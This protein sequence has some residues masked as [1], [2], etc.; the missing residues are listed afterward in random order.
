MSR[1]WILVAPASRGI[2]AHLT[3]HLLRTTTAPILA[4]CRSPDTT[5]VKQSILSSL[6]S[7]D[8]KPKSHSSPAAKETEDLASRL[9][10]VTLD[11][12]SEP[13][14]AAAAAEAAS[15]FPSSTH[16]LR[17]ALATPGIL[18][19][20]KSPA[21]IDY[22]DALETFRVNTL[23]QMMLMKHFSPFLPK[24]SVKFSTSSSPENDEAR[25]LP[26][27]HAVWAAMSARVGSTA[28]NRKGGWY[29]YRA[30][31]AGVTS[32]AKSLDLWLAARS[33]ERAMAVAYHPGTVKTGLSRGFWDTVP[34]GKLFEPE[35]AV[36]RM[37]KV[38]TEEVGIEGRGRF[39]DWAGKEILP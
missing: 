34:E 26:P 29:S 12:T 21:Q 25:G 14:I 24:K 22:D 20:E 36:E 6:S 10:V 27:S 37:C 7:S 19:P 8:A 9:K 38:L 28:D 13:T 17:L 16:H 11:V 30:S 3:R 5:A 4:T 2:G 15:L 31:K 33:G 35:Y 39:W 23:G 18:H 1:P 32:L